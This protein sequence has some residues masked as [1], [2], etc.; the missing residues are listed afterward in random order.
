M[1]FRTCIP[2]TQYK[3]QYAFVNVLGLHGLLQIRAWGSLEGDCDGVELDKQNWLRL[4]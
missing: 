1:K 2:G 3:I 4:V